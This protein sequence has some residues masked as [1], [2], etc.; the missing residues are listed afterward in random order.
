MQAL[1]SRLL[2]R[3]PGACPSAD[4][5]ASGR[6][7]IVEPPGQATCGHAA[8]RH[9]SRTGRRCTGRCEASRT[10]ASEDL[11]DDVGPHPGA[12]PHV[13][14]TADTASP[15][16]GIRRPASPDA[17]SLEAGATSLATAWGSAALP[18]RRR[19]SARC[20]AERPRADPGAGGGVRPRGQSTWAAGPV[21]TTGSSADLAAGDR[22]APAPA[23]GRHCARVSVGRAPRRAQRWDVP[24]HLDRLRRKASS[25]P[26]ER[27]NVRSTDRRGGGCP[28]VAQAVWESSRFAARSN[29]R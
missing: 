8:Q 9:D 10:C 29:A 3:A 14:W 6:Q 22:P 25:D 1:R 15:C 13:D 12:G 21:G 27:C 17:G 24:M 4:V 16:R 28:G 2:G 20:R 5:S 19:R 18:G 7:A 23:T 26:D 11:N